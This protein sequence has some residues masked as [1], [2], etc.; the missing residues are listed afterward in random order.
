ML[1][2]EELEEVINAIIR[3]VTLA[4]R[5]EQLEDFLYKWGL[6]VV[7]CQEKVPIKLK[8]CYYLI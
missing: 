5:T 8:Y 1:K 6:E 2:S 4:N 3:K 7:L